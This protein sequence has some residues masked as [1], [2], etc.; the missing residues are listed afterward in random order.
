[1]AKI[2]YYAKHFIMVRS[3]DTERTS[4]DHVLET[5]LQLSNSDQN[6]DMRVVV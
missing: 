5:G 3:T 6:F 4:V 2:S 1:M